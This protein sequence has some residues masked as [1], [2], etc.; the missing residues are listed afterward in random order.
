M[1][2]TNMKILILI[3]MLTLLSGCGGKSSG[4]VAYGNAPVSASM[5]TGG[6]VYKSTCSICHKSGLKGAPRLGSKH[7]WESRLAQG[8]DILYGHAINGYVGKKGTMPSRGSNAKLTENEVKEAVDY[9]VAHAI[10]AWEVG[11]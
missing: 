9:M 11:K 10:P 6:N 5:I 2:I 8:N 4:T 3:V 7:D 1:I